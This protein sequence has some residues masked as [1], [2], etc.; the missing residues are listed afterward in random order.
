MSG[1][2]FSFA[3]RTAQLAFGGA[4]FAHQ[5]HFLP[6]Q[7]S[8]GLGLGAQLIALAGGFALRGS[9]GD[10]GGHASSLLFA[11]RAMSFASSRM[12]SSVRLIR[13]SLTI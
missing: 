7:P 4:E 10:V 5:F 13:G 8:D 11:M 2:P 12:S 6:P 9:L 1:F 3:Q